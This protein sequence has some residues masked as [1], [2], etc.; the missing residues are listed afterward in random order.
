MEEINK[1]IEE[2]IER[3]TTEHITCLLE[4]ISQTFDISMK[5][6]L[7]CTIRTMDDKATRCMGIT[8]NK[9]RCKNPPKDNGYC[10]VHNDQYKPPV[11]PSST[12]IKH[13]HTLP[14]L[15]KE[16]C[17]ACMRNKV[18]DLDDVFKNGEI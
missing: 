10:K 18:R 17:P 3:R 5:S 13:N 14:P 2:E 8:K 15:Y 4:S 9:T 16:G 11:K 7:K 12:A 6:L 1:L